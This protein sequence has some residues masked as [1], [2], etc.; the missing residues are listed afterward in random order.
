MW[1]IKQ[2]YINPFE[3]KCKAN[4]ISI[5]WNIIE[6][7]KT[8]A[9]PEWWWQEWDRWVIT[10]FK[11]WNKI[12]FV[13]CKKSMWRTLFLK[14]FPT[15]NVDT[16][17]EH[18]IWEQDLVLLREFNI[19]DEV[20]I[21]IDIN[22]RKKLSTSHTTCHLLYIWVLKYRPDEINN[23]R[24]CHIIEDSARLDFYTDENFTENDIKTITNIVN[25]LIDKNLKVSTYA[26]K[27]EPEALFWECDWVV[28]PC[29]W[30]HLIETWSIWNCFI[31]RKNIGKWKERL[32]IKF[33]EAKFDDIK[34]S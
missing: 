1:T 6:L 11:N 15:I 13:D 2:Y 26:Y 31:K 28:M 5:D 30:T 24:W 33:P 34:Y 20:E 17:V 10:L 14:D 21:E 9:F 18:I 22:R 3:T 12:N 29:W 25:N 32:I 7:D 19:W 8:I 4:I 27:N 16:I 23:I